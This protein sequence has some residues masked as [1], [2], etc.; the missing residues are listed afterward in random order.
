[1][2]KSRRE[3]S[4]RFIGEYMNLPLVEG[5]KARI[6]SVLV[7]DETRAGFIRSAIEH[8]LERRGSPPAKMDAAE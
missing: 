8:E 1:M 2:A 7:Q 3:R 6:D 5:T 4:D